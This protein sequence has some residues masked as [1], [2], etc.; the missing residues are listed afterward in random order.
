M[1]VF[2]LF[3]IA[4][5]AYC[6]GSLN[7]AIISSR[8][9]FRKDVREF[10]SHNAG[11][12]NY[13]RCFGAP[14]VALVLLIDI[15]KSVIAVV[16]GG[17][18]LN[19]VGAPVIGKLFA[20]FCLMMGHVFPVFYG[21]HGGKAVLCGVVTATVVD[22]RVGLCCFL[23]FL[24]IVIFTRYVSLGSIAGGSLCPVFLW[25]FGY[26]P[27]ACVLGLLCAL[28]IDIRH[29]ENIVRLIGGTESKL[30]FGGSRSAGQDHYGDGR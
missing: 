28:L 4:I 13:Y 15:L 1:T 12:T 7:G 19:I 27:L 25:I 2:L 14:G 9:I 11:L 22:W 29:A 6:F 3:V 26:E 18:L 24:I 30:Q 10:G 20:G 17:A 16:I 8:F 23:V 21:L 5:I